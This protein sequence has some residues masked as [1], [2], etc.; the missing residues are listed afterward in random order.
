MLL[1][2]IALIQFEENDLLTL[3]T[4]RTGSREETYNPADPPQQVVRR[5]YKGW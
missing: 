3:T 2:P 1:K 5:N 4:N